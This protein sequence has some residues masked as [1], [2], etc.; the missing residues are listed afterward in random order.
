[1]HDLITKID[2]CRDATMAPQIRSEDDVSD[3]LLIPYELVESIKKGLAY[4][5]K[6]YASKYKMEINR[7]AIRCA[8]LSL[9]IDKLEAEQ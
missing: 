7:L 5:E 3:G 2:A 8:D 9:Q 6:D 4:G 1:M